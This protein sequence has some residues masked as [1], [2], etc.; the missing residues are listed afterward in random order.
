MTVFVRLLAVIAVGLLPS[1]AACQPPAPPPAQATAQ[2]TKQQSATV[3]SVD[4]GTRLVVLRAEDGTKE[5]FVASPEVRNLPQVRVGDKVT[6]TYQEAIAVRM[7]PVGSAAPNTAVITADRAAL[8]Q[9]PAA[10]INSEV[11]AR[12]T[13]VSAA[14]DGSSVTFMGPDGVTHTAEV[15]DPKMQAFVQQ[16]RPGNQV[17]IDY[18]SK[19]AVRVDRMN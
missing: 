11:T 14:P 3:E 5:S 2:R 17:D 12:V 4:M 19:I 15:R 1:L 10:A 9:M 7:A 6:A 16:L 8:G 13:V 18:S